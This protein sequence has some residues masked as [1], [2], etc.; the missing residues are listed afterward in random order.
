MEVAI[1]TSSSACFTCYSSS[2]RCHDGFMHG[3]G[4]VSS[5]WD[6]KLWDIS[7]AI[8]LLTI[9]NKLDI[10][11]SKVAKRNAIQGPKYAHDEWDIYLALD[12]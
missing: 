8:Q 2:R 9:L 6:S 11:L 10:K 5:L 1:T 7:K 4:G 12:F 3:Y